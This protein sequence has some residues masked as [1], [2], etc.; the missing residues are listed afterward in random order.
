MGYE[1]NSRSYVTVLCLKRI[2]NILHGQFGTPTMVHILCG[3]LDNFSRAILDVLG[4]G[5]DY[6]FIQISDSQ[7]LGI[8]LY[9]KGP[10]DE[11]SF[12]RAPASLSPQNE[13]LP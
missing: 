3:L 5:V 10:P 7:G 2:I 1:L 11:I 9:P 4:E 12:P 8:R 6:F 13:P